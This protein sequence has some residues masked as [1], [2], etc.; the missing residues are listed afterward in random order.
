MPNQAGTATT[1]GA[2]LPFSDN[3]SRDRTANEPPAKSRTGAA[4]AVIRGWAPTR[5]LILPSNRV[6]RSQ[7]VGA[8]QGPTVVPSRQTTQPGRKPLTS[9]TSWVALKLK[10]QTFP[11]LLTWTMVAMATVAPTP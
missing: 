6:S 3:A 2:S 9:T 10:R 4:G 11:S 1:T 5:R 8:G 7:T